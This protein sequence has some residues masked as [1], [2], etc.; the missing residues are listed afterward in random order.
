MII[1]AF[2]TIKYAGVNIANIM[3]CPATFYRRIKKNYNITTVEV[4][5]GMRADTLSY[6][7]YGT[8]Y[9]QWVFTVLNP[10]I[11]DGGLND[12]LMDENSIFL[13]T[14]NKYQNIADPHEVHH[15]VDVTETKWFNVTNE[16]QGP[17]YWYN[18]YDDS[19]TLLYSGVMTPV[20]YLEYERNENDRKFKNIKIIDPK[21]I[22]GF[23]NDMIAE[24]RRGN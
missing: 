22:S 7:L 20:S 6:T 3:K 8:P 15:H 2:E 1:S 5:Y 14:E 9:L 18:K 24:I 12:W 4:P 10:Q 16:N 19:E 17:N 23:V 21:E 11:Q 13:Y